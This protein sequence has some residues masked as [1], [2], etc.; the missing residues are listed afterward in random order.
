MIVFHEE[1]LNRI[2]KHLPLHKFSQSKFGKKT[3]PGT[4]HENQDG[5]WPC[6]FTDDYNLANYMHAIMDDDEEEEE[7][8]Y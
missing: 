6:Y 8:H 5:G 2:H 7:K 3:I 1:F 4:L